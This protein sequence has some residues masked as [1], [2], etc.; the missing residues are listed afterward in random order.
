MLKLK[1]QKTESQSSS[2]KTIKENSMNLY[3]IRLNRE[4]NVR[5]L[6]SSNIMSSINNGMM[7]SYKHKVKMP[8]LSD[9]LRE[10]M[11]KS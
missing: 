11:D 3:S 6:I 8:R 1:W 4:K 2:F 5:M 10:L 9:N 7:I